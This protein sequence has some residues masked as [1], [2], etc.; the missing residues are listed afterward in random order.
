[1][2]S[3]LYGDDQGKMCFNP[4]KIWQLQFFPHATTAWYDD[5]AFV[6]VNT[7]NGAQTFKMMGVGEYSL[8]GEYDVTCDIPHIAFLSF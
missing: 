8:Q 3:P 7:S 1:M 5:E 2:G 6:S 4:A